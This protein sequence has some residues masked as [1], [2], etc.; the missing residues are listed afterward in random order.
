MHFF[1]SLEASSRWL[2][3]H[4]EAT[5]LPAEDAF[6]LGRLIAMG[7]VD[8]SGLAEPTNAEGTGRLD[9]R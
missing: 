9:E 8:I 2:K 7:L 5:I 4:P 1:S 6:R 3:R